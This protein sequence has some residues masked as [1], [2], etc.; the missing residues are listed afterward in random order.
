MALPDIVRAALDDEPVLDRI[1]LDSE[2]ELFVTSTRL[3]HHRSEGLLSDESIEEFRHDVERISVSGGCRTTAIALEYAGDERTLSVPADRLEAVLDLFFAE[4]L[5]VDGVIDVD[6]RI[7]EA[8]RLDELTAV[9]TDHRLIEHIGA[10]V[11]DGEY[12]ETSF[13]GVTELEIERGSVATGIVLTADGRRER[14]KVRNERARPF[15]ERL[16]RAIRAYHGVESVD[17]LAVERTETDD[18]SNDRP[19]ESVDPLT[20]DGPNGPEA[21]GYAVVRLSPKE[22][23]ARGSER[24]LPLEAELEALSEAIEEHEALLED[25]RRTIE[26][27]RKA[28]TRDRGR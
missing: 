7:V 24:E 3:L 5:S 28:L 15:E 18:R 6:E 22:S 11:W 27:L 4:V 17:E 9:V 23:T 13:D 26:R 12:E 21:S 2:R 25:Q 16:R 8:F 20:I 19:L 1:E 10:A 14:I